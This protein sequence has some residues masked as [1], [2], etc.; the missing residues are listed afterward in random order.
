MKK[1]ALI[2][3]VYTTSAG[4]GGLTSLGGVLTLTADGGAGSIPGIGAPVMLP[5]APVQVQ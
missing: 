3:D 1:A 5:L 4:F 2:R